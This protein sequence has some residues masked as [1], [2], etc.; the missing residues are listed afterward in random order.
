[1][2]NTILC[3]EEEEKELKFVLKN[4]QLHRIVFRNILRPESQTIKTN[5][6]LDHQQLA[7]T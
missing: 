2:Q 6:W 3:K 1:M 7:G 5:L 4:S